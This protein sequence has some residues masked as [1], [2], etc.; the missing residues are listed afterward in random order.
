MMEVGRNRYRALFWVLGGTAVVLVSFRATLAVMDTYSPLLRRHVK[1]SM[2]V[3][4]K[5]EVCATGP[6]E[7]VF[8]GKICSVGGLNGSSVSV[9]WQSLANISTTNPSCG[10]GKTIKWNRVDHDQKWIRKYLGNC[11]L[12]PAYFES[13]PIVFQV[14]QLEMSTPELKT[15]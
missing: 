11:E 2:T 12:G 9:R 8:E 4:G 3:S 5:P 6:S 15:K 7:I 14:G 10:I 1:Y 13:M